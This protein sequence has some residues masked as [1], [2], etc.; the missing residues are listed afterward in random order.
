MPKSLDHEKLKV[1]RRS[2]G[3]L[4]ADP[5]T[6]HVIFRGWGWVGSDQGDSARPVR[7]GNFLTRPD[8]TRQDLTRETLNTS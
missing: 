3:S 4:A 5:S 6:A 1:F 8:P 2:G 7:F